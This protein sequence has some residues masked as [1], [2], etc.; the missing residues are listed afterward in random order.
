MNP[1]KLGIIAV[2]IALLPISSLIL[3][4][5]SGAV[6]AATFLPAPQPIASVAYKNAMLE[7]RVASNASVNITTVFGDT[8]NF[9]SNLRSSLR[10]NRINNLSVGIL[11]TD[12]YVSN[13]RASFEVYAPMAT[14]NR[15]LSV[16][17]AISKSPLDDA[18]AAWIQTLLL[19]NK[20]QLTAELAYSV[21]INR[22]SNIDS[23][24]IYRL[25]PDGGSGKSVASLRFSTRF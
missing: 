7:N 22:Y 10:S 14:V 19:I 12:M 6:L 5:D 3:P 9:L 23:G 13:D 11:R 15:A 20:R 16:V 1:A 25:N 8:D 24:I 21:K 17:K 2:L 18:V 4:S